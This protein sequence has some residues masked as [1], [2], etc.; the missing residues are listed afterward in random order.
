MCREG[1]IYRGTL[2]QGSGATVGVWRHSSATASRAL[3][4]FFWCTKDGDLPQVL[5]NGS[6]DYVDLLEELAPKQHPIQLRPSFLVNEEKPQSGGWE[7]GGGHT[8]I[9]S[10][11]VYRILI[12]SDTL[13]EQEGGGGGNNSQFYHEFERHFS[14]CRFNLICPSMSERGC[15]KMGFQVEV[16]NADK[17]DRDLAEEAVNVCEAGESHGVDFSVEAGHKLKVTFW[18]RQE[19]QGCGNSIDCL[20][21]KPPMGPIL[22]PLGP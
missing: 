18:H 16:S 11:N 12:S 15:R 17:E 10:V 22:G 2:G 6:V 19:L 3:S 14:D 5:G 1:E 20:L 7:G 9:S 21:F 4:C 13:V 8:A